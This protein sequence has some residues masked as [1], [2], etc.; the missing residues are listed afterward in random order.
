[1][2]DCFVGCGHY[3]KNRLGPRVRLFNYL[4]WHFLMVNEIRLKPDWRGVMSHR[5]LACMTAERREQRIR[6][7]ERLPTQQKS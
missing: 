5:M 3:L 4:Y 1:M 7:T 6:Q 2:T